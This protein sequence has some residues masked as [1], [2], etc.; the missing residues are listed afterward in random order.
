VTEQKQNFPVYSKKSINVALVGQPNVGKSTVFNMLTGLNQHVG[1]WPGK[2]VELKT[3]ELVHNETLIHLV[4]LPGTYSLTANSEEERITRDFIIREKPD[5]VIA[6]VN[7]AMLERNLYLVAELL[8]LDVPF[9]LGLNMVDV[10]NQQGLRIEVNV[11]EA[12]LRVPVVPV[13]ASK[14]QGLF[15]L[16]DAAQNLAESPIPLAPNRPD[17]RPE[18]RPVLEEIRSLIIGQVPQPYHVD[19][20]ALK[21]L[22]GDSEVMEMVEQAAP[23]AWP[24]IQTLLSQHEDAILDITGGRY[25]WIARMVRVAIVRPRP[26][27]IVLTD[28]LDRIATH[29]FW[30]LVLLL[31]I[32]GIVFWLTYH[33]AMPT[34]NGWTQHSLF[35]C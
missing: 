2:T 6:I 5:V 4:D 24:R 15:E 19:W 29:P 14:N 17:I 11:L 32:L 27:T 7:A 1:N 23:R 28:R 9:V 34:W 18:H 13:I 10:A 22:E 20:V 25:E 35:H 12:A 30:G 26:G 31:G 21:L 16:I 8:A 33:V 3:G